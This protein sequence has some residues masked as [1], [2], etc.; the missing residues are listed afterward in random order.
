MHVLSISF[1]YIRI[2]FILIVFNLI[3]KFSYCQLHS[4]PSGFVDKSND[5]ISNI[6]GHDPLLYN[7]ILYK[8]YYPSNVKGHQYLMG[9]EYLNGEVTIRNVQFKNLDLNF[10]IYNQQLLLS[11][12]NASEA[13]MISQVWLESFSIGKLNFRYYNL[14]SQTKHLFQVIENDSIQ[15]LYYWKKDMQPESVNGSKN[16]VFIKKRESMLLKNSTLYKYNNNSSFRQ[17][18]SKEKQESIKKYMKLH[19]IK[20]YTASD[21]DM[22]KLIN[23]CSKL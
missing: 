4:G 6:Y 3:N 8:S 12:K 5:S 9:P 10:D 17:L 13:I 16:L 19:K 15:L 22:Q 18:F 11:T 20:I 23:Y 21:E 1:T 14:P 2:F 7:G